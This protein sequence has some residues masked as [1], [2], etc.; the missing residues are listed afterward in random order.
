MREREAVGC[1][2]GYR[3][4]AD[5]VS[6]RWCRLSVIMFGTINRA[7]LSLRCDCKCEEL[8]SEVNLMRGH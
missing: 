3:L 7:L 6:W 2:N 5:Q 4:D 1:D 8:T